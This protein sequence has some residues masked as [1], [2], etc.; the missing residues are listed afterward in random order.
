MEKIISGFVENIHIVFIVVVILCFIIP[1]I[2]TSVKRNKRKKQKDTLNQRTILIDSYAGSNLFLS[3]L[4]MPLFLMGGFAITGSAIVAIIKTNIIFNIICTIIFA[5]VPGIILLMIPIVMIVKNSRRFIKILKGS[6]V[7]VLD[8]L[9]DKY[10]YED[11]SHNVDGIDLSVWQ[12]YFKDFYKKY[13]KFIKLKD[14][15][16]G[17]KYEIGEKF[18][19]VFVK[20]ESTPYKF[21]AKEYTL[22]PS[23]KDKLKTIDD[24][25][26]YIDLEEFVLE[27][28]I[29]SEIIVINKERII[30]DFFDKKRKTGLVVD[31]LLPIGILLFG[32]IVYILF[33]VLI[34]LIPVLAVFVFFLIMNTTHIKHILNMLN[35]IKNNNYE[36]KEDEIVSLNNRLSYSDSN[37]MI[38]FKLKNYKKIVYQDKKYFADVK[39]GDKL[40]LVF[41]KGEKEP[42]KV[43]NAKYSTMERK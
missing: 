24:V 26:D 27:K 32:I 33:S 30:N 21:R 8:E 15:R 17:N 4:F 20:G 12:L 29:P 36:V 11:H 2:Y 25:K 37:R 22:A 1:M 16:E 38:S 7:I 40:Y 6:Y 3:I 42:I 34:E 18:Y 9:M 5:I 35:Q 10:Y 39:E 41:V 23:E 31:I 19:L 13:D 14:L 28:E 43:Y